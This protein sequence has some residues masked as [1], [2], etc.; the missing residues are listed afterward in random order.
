M[1]NSIGVCREC[2]ERHE[3]CHD[4]CE[5]YQ[6]RKAE[7]DALREHMKREKASELYLYKLDL[8]MKSKAK[9]NRKVLEGWKRNQ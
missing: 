1:R 3:A 5:K 7:C 8:I 9:K 6:K 4:K 2:T